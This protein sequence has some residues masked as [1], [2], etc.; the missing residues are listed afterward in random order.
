[1]PKLPPSP[2]A[3]S[4][5]I[6]NASSGVGSLP[7]SATT[8]GI[9]NTAAA[10]LSSSTTGLSTGLGSYGTTGY[11]SSYGSGY[12]SSYGGYGS[13]Y[14]GYG[15]YGGYGSYGMG[16][17]MGGMYGMGRYGIMGQD[18]KG[19]LFNTMITLDSFSYL[20]NCLC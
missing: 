12:G 6:T 18:K 4:D 9:G 11:G 8:N 17:G 7:T 5:I 16:M 13:S 15:G 14:G 1:M 3:A 10:G 20:I 2:I 19:F